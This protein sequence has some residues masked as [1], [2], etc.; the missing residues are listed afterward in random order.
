MRLSEGR[1]LGDLICWSQGTRGRKAL[2]EVT[3][4]HVQDVITIKRVSQGTQ[5][6]GII[7]MR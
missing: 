2:I 5:F 1:K 3:P 7:T 6:S 4:Q